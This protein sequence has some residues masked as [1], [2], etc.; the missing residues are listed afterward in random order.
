MVI[1]DHS[2]GL[3]ARYTRRGA[4][5]LLGL[6]L[7]RVMIVVHENGKDICALYTRGWRKCGILYIDVQS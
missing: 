3:Y 6:L 4:K 2:K 5:I 7:Q 1:L